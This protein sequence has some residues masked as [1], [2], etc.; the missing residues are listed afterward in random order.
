M[1]ECAA[2]FGDIFRIQIS[3]YGTAAIVS[4]PELI[5]E[6]FAGSAD[7]FL[8]GKSNE[9][10]RPFVGSNS[11][12]VLD[13]PEHQRQR[14]LLMPALHGERM[15]AYGQAMLELTNAAI[16]SWPLHQNFA[17]HTQMQV[18]TLR[19]ILRT[20]FGVA[21]GP[22]FERLFVLLHEGVELASNPL[23]LFPIM[24]RELGG[25][26]PWG[27]FMHMSRQVDEILREEVAQRRK[28]SDADARADVLTMLMKARDEHGQEM[29][30]Q[31][32]RD[33]LVTMLVAG[34]ETTATAL[35]WTMVGLLQDSALCQKLR[36]ELA[37]A[38]ENGHLVPEKIAKLELL[39]ATVREGLRLHPIAP[40]VGRLLAKPIQLGGF[41]I[42]AGWVVAPSVYLAHHRASVFQ[43]PE[44]FEPER[45][46]QSRPSP[47]DWLPFGGGVRRCPGAAFATYEMKLVLAS[48]LWRTQLRLK[49]GYVAKPTRRGVTLAP[50]EKVPVIMDQRST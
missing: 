25:Y 5:K 18:I 32:L 44:R 4:S 11:V 48:I 23:L 33:E 24:Q 35:G 9:M 29:S 26:S 1:A 27:R 30:F 31:E 50:S 19:V 13:G 8:G 15:H 45:F 43:N 12:L 40:V 36:D 42:P 17:L 47:S 2:R 37:G 39:D 6:I 49:P 22:Q 21:A 41:D 34:H 28:S 20:I 38:C 7:V 46:L 14:K 3:G 10:V 16:D